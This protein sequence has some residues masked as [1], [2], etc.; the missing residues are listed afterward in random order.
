MRSLRW[1][2]MVFF[3]AASD[4]DGRGIGK[5]QG[6]ASPVDPQKEGHRRITEEV[7]KETRAFIE[8][9]SQRP[10]G[11]CGL[12]DRWSQITLVRQA[13]LPMEK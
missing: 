10:P 1:L 7:I 3:A 13:H 5:N 2:A 11:L 8:E 4:R 12:A 9:I 6:R